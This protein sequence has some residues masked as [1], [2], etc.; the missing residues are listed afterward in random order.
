MI[1]WYCEERAHQA[2]RFLSASSLL[3]AGEVSKYCASVL[4]DILI[5]VSLGR[6]SLPLVFGTK[7]G[8]FM[9]V[10]LLEYFVRLK[11]PFRL[12]DGL[13]MSSFKIK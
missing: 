2:S 4:Y 9:L 12:F 6:D 10:M 11:V 7:C 5:I 8:V 1:G 13:F 3:F